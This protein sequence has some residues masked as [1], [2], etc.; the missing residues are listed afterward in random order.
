MGGPPI[1]RARLV[2]E[3]DH[4]A[5]I[6][7]P[8]NV[9]LPSGAETLDLSGRTV[10]PGLIDLH[11]H[12]ENDPKLA[13]RQ[14]SHGVTA[15]RD[16]GQWNEKFEVLRKTIA[17]DHL[18]GPS[19]LHDRSAHRRRTSGLSCRLGCGARCGRGTSSCRAERATGRVGT[20]IYFRLPFA[21]AKAVID[22]CQA[23]HIPCTAHLEI[24]D[25]RELIEAGLTGVEHITSLGFG[26][27][28]QMEAEAY[29]QAVLADND[30]RR[31]GRYRMFVAN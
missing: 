20:E 2:V 6:G 29:R 14:L 13:L 5:R 10:I 22:V 4:V 24:L 27:L 8:A 18:P 15:F 26:L 3:G 12:I 31:D 7:A 17:D 16:P 30:A 9:P 23:R 11:F 1:E 19:D 21:S 28:P 25:A